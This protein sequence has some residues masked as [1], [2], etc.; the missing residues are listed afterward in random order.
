ME[1]SSKVVGIRKL[2][3]SMEN[4]INF[5]LK[6]SLKLEKL[7]F[8]CWLFSINLCC[9]IFWHS[10]SNNCSRTKSQIFSQIYPQREIWTH[11]AL[12]KTKLYLDN[13]FVHLNWCC[14]ELL[15]FSEWEGEEM[16]RDWKQIFLMKDHLWC[17]HSGV[18]VFSEL[19]FVRMW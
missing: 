14:W 19:F 9:N 13:I 7:I 15:H 8:D 11:T 1:F 16:A 6:P 4:S 5:F 17:W 12:N 2:T 3:L 18:S 10:Q